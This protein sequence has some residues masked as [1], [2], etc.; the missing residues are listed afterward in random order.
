VT[1]NHTSLL[2]MTCN[3]QTNHVLKT[4]T[5]ALVQ[6][7]R[8]LGFLGL[9]L[10]GCATPCWTLTA[11]S[12]DSATPTITAPSRS[13]WNNAIPCWT[14]AAGSADR[15]TSTV[16]TPAWIDHNT[17]FG[18]TLT[19]GSADRATSTVDACSHNLLS[20]SCRQFIRLA[21]M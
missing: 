9:H 15:A 21:Y 7:Q 12:A 11:G 4:R 6:L 14:L 18:W 1:L 5:V 8:V 20:F 2:K 10:S 17:I 19:A 16:A 13:R 3:T